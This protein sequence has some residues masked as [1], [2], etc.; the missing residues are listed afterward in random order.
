MSQEGV[1]A[2]SLVRAFIS[3]QFAL[4]ILESAVRTGTL[5]L[6]LGLYRERVSGLRGVKAILST[7]AICRI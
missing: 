3:F 6:A 4:K 5:L 7:S 1:L 2:L